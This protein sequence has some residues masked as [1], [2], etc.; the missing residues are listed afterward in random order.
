LSS[1]ALRAQRRRLRKEKL[2]KGYGL[3]KSNLLNAKHS[4]ETSQ[5][6]KQNEKEIWGSSRS[7]PCI[8]YYSGFT[9]GLSDTQ[10][11]KCIRQKNVRRFRPD[12]Y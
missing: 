2:N 10:I 4:P 3:N 6:E 8:R 1:S 9:D 5:S 11:I 7:N 12:I